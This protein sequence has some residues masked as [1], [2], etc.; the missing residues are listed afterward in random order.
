[1]TAYAEKDNKK[2]S[3]EILE[4]ALARFK[5]VDE[6]EAQLRRDALDDLKFRSGE[7]WPDEVKKNRELDRRP[8]LT[9]NRLPQFIKQITNDQRQNRPAIQVSPVDD[10]ADP[11][12]AEVL[13]GLI[14]HIEYDSNADIAYDTAFDGAVT[15]GRGY[16]RVV[17]KYCDPM[18][19]EQNPKIK[20]IRNPQSVYMD[21]S[22]QE[23][24]YSDA[25]YGFIIEDMT[26]DEFKTAYPNSELASLNDWESV[27]SRAPGWMEKD[28]VRIA[29]YFYKEY[30]EVEIALLVDKTVVLKASLPEDFPK[31][32]IV[33]TRKTKIPT[34]KWCKLSA[35]EILDET[36]WPGQWIPI[37]PVLGDEI[38]IDGKVILE[39][40]IRHAKDP[41]RMY[42]Y[43]A[44]S[45]TETIALA[46]RAPWVGVEGQ[47]EGH[48]EQWQTANVRNHAYLEYNPKSI[49]GNLSPPPTRNVFEPPIQAITQARMQ[50]AE[51]LKSTT[52]IYDAALGARGNEI[53]GVAIH[54]RNS[55]SQTGNF[56]YVDNLTRSI[57]HLGRIL[58]DLIPKVYDTERVLRVIGEDGTEKIVVINR[59]LDESGKRI[60]FSEGKYDVTISTGPGYATKRQEALDS[61][62]QLTQAYPQIA[63]IAGDLMV[64]NMDWPG[65]KD[66]SE[67]LKKTLPPGLVDQEGAQ[68]GQMPPE[69]AQQMEQMQGMI[70]NLTN[71]L[72]EASDKLESKDKDLESNERIAF[73]KLQVELLKEAAKLE[74]QE[75]RALFVSEIKN[76]DKRLQIVGF[77]EPIDG[78][79]QP[80]Q[81]MS[82]GQSGSG[83]QME[84]MPGQPGSGMQVPEGIPAQPGDTGQLPPE[85]P[86]QFD[87][88]EQPPSG[89]PLGQ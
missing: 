18:S 12:T 13:Q 11:E 57:R 21:P 79:E 59:I 19:F 60:S 78:S 83:R 75:S 1:M 29:E 24:D 28:R 30:E 35:T 50:S 5:L 38:D 48:E 44:S 51:D 9:I 84:G 25:E 17:T 15:H 3:E 16:F 43:W 42:N 7:Q 46:P 27:G 55:Q 70:E 23:P 73:A 8:C 56:H 61:M 74:S 88:I 68:A 41:Q 89:L 52:G 64:K 67:R 10:L 49:G 32:G 62:L 40:V 26:K 54:R 6:A 33:G 31:E 71:S 65:A 20:R 63:H 2:T 39:G 87:N 86:G 4:R 81:G 45:E 80:P 76:L 36:V 47:F 66:I 82:L 53:S 72:N 85:I 34:I 77:N 69:I 37:I 22:C 14:R 58:I